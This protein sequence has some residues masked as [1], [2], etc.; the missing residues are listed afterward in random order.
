LLGIAGTIITS[1]SAIGDVRYS[2][3]V[4]HRGLVLKGA[5]DGP[6]ADK[7]DEPA[8]SEPGDMADDPD[9]WDLSADRGGME[10]GA[11]WSIMHEHTGLWLKMASDG[12]VAE[13]RLSSVEYQY[14]AHRIKIG[15]NPPIRISTQDCNKADAALIESQLKAGGPVVR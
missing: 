4:D 7:G 13:I 10:E 6:A 2:Y 15:N 12:H 1:V 5:V 11:R 14:R 8:Q 3:L 9:A